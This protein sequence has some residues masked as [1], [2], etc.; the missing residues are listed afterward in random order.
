MNDYDGL[1]DKDEVELK[2]VDNADDETSRLGSNLAQIVDSEA[3]TQELRKFPHET[4]EQIRKVLMTDEILQ[5]IEKPSR[6]RS[7]SIICHINWILN[8]M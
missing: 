3:A 6:W 8:Q 7:T 4:Q 1:L 5:Y 2:L